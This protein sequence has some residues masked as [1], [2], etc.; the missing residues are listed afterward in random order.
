MDTEFFL[1]FLF[2]WT[3]TDEIKSGLITFL[4]MLVVCAMMDQH[5]RRRIF[6]LGGKT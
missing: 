2:V 4:A 5:L 6:L 3:G 1:F